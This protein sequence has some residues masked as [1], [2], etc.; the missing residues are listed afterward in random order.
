MPTGACGVNCDTCKL[1]LMEICSSCGSGRSSEGRKK[2]IAQEK[3]LGKPC[4][5]LACASMNNVDYCMRDC[6]SFPCDN[7]KGG[8]YPFSSGFLSMQE[9]RRKLK[10]PA[11]T[12]NLTPLEVPS[13]FWETLQTKNLNLLCNFTLFRPGPTGT[14][15]FRSL[16]EDVLVDVGRRCLKTMREGEW[17]PADDPLLELMTLLYLNSVGALYPLGKDIVGPL[18]LREAHYFKGRHVIKT[19]PLLERYGNDLIGFKQAAEYL[20]GTPTTMA[21]AAY[22][23]LPFPR[24]PLYY[25]LWEGD[26]EFDPRLSVLFDRS[27]ENYF[28]A[29]AIWSLINWVSTELLRGPAARRVD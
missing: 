28:A 6:S 22:M 4:P 11:L 25:L 10:P 29:S 20:G 9:R 16:N 27:I 21:D 12:H 23:M 5:V 8:P 7:F 17:A 14:L 13:E 24:V 1:R 2:A 26:E 3:I 15:V 19:G 18:D